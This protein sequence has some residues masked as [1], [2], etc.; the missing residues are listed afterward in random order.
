MTTF[1]DVIAEM[2]AVIKT[3]FALPPTSPNYRDIRAASLDWR[4]TIA[5]WQAGSGGLT[6]PYVITEIGRLKSADAWSAM[7]DSR[8]AMP[9]TV[10]WIG[11]IG[12]SIEDVDA[13][14]QALFVALRGDFATF[15][16]IDGPEIDDT[17][18]NAANVVF[19]EMAVPLVAGV[20]TVTLM[21]SD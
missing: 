9:V 15:Q 11:P 3:A 1:E 13:Q 10:T 20:L 8:Y 6:P 14:M 16:V 21:C 2:N 19:R 5:Q 4:G 18:R 17:A 12:A 7:D